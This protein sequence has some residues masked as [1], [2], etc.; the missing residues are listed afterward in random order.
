MNADALT[1]R[2]Q[3]RLDLFNARSS[4]EAGF[5]LSASIGVIT[6]EPDRP[7][8]DR[9]DAQPG[10]PAHVRAEAEPE[11]RRGEPGKPPGPSK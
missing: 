2:L 11:G 10:R 8:D 6:R 5:T 1:R 9:G 4:A 7:D 3:D